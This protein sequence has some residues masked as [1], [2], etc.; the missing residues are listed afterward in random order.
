MVCFLKI[1]SNTY[2]LLV[3]VE[4]KDMNE[5]RH[6]LVGRFY[7]ELNKEWQAI[8]FQNFGIVWST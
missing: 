4:P 3:L 5:S 2:G 7:K 6:G 1:Y 8:R